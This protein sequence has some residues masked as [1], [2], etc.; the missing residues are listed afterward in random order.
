[1]RKPE[2]LREDI[3]LSGDMHGHFTE[4]RNLEGLPESVKEQVPDGF[5]IKKY[6]L[7]KER[8]NQQL[9][10]INY[11][12]SLIERARI[13][14]RRQEFVRD[15]FKEDLPN[16]VLQSQFIVGSGDYSEFIYEIQSKLEDA[17]AIN[18]ETIREHFLGK[19]EIIQ[20]IKEQLRKFHKRG[21]LLKIQQEFSEFKG[22]GVD[23][24]PKGENVVLT[25][26]GDLRIID[27][28]FLEPADTEYAR[29][30]IRYSGI[31]D[32]L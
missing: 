19:P 20:K 9:F 7:D 25:K 12:E 5:V 22:L 24:G 18:I 15:F 2:F 4:V 31:A 17:I 23:L 16:L 29:R 8:T 28:N 3:S 13:L 6:K 30:Y 10:G 32:Q 26:D 27:T 14:K 1:M 21:R 11:E